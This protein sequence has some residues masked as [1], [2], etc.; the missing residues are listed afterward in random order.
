MLVTK[1]RKNAIMKM[2][3]IMQRSRSLVNIFRPV[4]FEEQ[5]LQPLSRY[6]GFDRGMPIDRYY[7]EKFLQQYS[8]NITGDVLE[9]A[10][11]LYMNKFGT[12]VTPHILHVNDSVKEATITGDLSDVEKMPENLVDCFICT[13][14]FHCIYNI[15]DAIRGAYKILKNN[16]VLLATVTGI[17]PS[18]WNDKEEWGD[19]WRFTTMAAERLFSACFPEVVV[20]GY[21]NV[22]AAKASLDGLAVEDIKD[23]AALDCHDADY[24]V[25][26]GIFARKI[27][28]P[29]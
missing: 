15:Q 14:T 8:A 6:F 10:E 5:R 17:G 28:P 27:L 7:I 1:S 3:R 29:A 2:F 4:N 20:H 11:D 18:S 24:P 12:N 25:I 13:Q 23:T 9:I 16:G 22:F 26:I 19:Y 21:G